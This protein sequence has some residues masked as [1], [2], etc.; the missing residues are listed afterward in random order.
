MPA[1]IEDVAALLKESLV[2]WRLDGDVGLEGG[3]I[4]VQAG[5]RSV[6][7]GP[8]PEGTPIAWTVATAE[9]MRGVT[10]LTA[11]LRAVRN[12]LDPEHAGSRLRLA[13][14]GVVPS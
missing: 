13:P 12:A 6:R 10:S 3:A 7:V 8:G 1:S 5:G 2:V 9:K 4:V 14:Q 11:L